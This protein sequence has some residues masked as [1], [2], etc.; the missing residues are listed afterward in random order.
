MVVKGRWLRETVECMDNECVIGCYI[1]G[2]RPK[3]LD[4]NIPFSVRVSSGHARP[5]AI[6]ADDTPLIEAVWIGIFNVC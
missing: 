6:N 1:N 5:R 3:T 2:W 4:V